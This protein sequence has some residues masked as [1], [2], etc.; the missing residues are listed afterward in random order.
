ML[1]Y[2]AVEINTEKLLRSGQKYQENVLIE[3][4]MA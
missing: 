2:L 3:N 4:K 1:Q